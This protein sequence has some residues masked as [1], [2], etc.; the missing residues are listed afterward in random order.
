MQSCS[1][2]FTWNTSNPKMSNTPMLHP[3]LPRNKVPLIFVTTKSNTFAYKCFASESL[4]SAACWGDSGMCSTSPLIWEVLQQR[5]RSSTSGDN[6]NREEIFRQSAGTDTLLPASTSL[7]GEKVTLPRCRTAARHWNIW[8]CVLR[9]MERVSRELFR[10]RNSFKSDR[11]S[12][13]R[14]PLP[15]R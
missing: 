3:T 11:L 4:W 9:S 5:D 15:M 12:T 6:P 10:V 7:L 14:Q 2:E 8:Y 1:K 13:V